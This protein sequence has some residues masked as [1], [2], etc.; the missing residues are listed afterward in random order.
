MVW[1]AVPFLMSVD[2]ERGRE[3]ARGYVYNDGGGSM[4]Y[5]RLSQEDL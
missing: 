4:A 5:E 3:D 1:A 2:V